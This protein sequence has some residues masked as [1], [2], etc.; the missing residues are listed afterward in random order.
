M[1]LT[2]HGYCPFS[3]KTLWTALFASFFFGLGW[4]WQIGLA[5]FFTFAFVESIAEDFYKAM[6]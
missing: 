3:S 5:A 2:E 1:K 6:P 4:G